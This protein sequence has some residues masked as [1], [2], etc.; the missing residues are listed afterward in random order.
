MTQENKRSPW[1]VQR[2]VIFALFLRELK[3]R[4]ESPTQYLWA[5]IEPMVFIL[6][7]LMIFV[8]IGR[9][10]AGNIPFPM[11]LL[12]GIVPW[13]FFAKSEGQASTAIPRNVGLFF[14]RQVKPIDTILTRVFLELVVFVLSFLIFLLIY[15]PLGWAS[16]P[17]EPLKL[18]AVYFVYVI[19]VFSVSLFLAVLIFFHGKMVSVPLSFFRRILYFISGVF[20]PITIFPQQYRSYFLWNPLI[21][22]MELSRDAYFA[23]YHSEYGSWS[24]L[25]L[26]TLVMFVI[27]MT[28]YRIN[29]FTLLNPST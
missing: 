16:L 19:L 12:T 24:F 27:G 9:K 5:I 29:R 6:F 1:F 8:V 2:S 10:S 21:H 3:T 28:Y 20:F 15:W 13:Q 17:N 23:E 4:F 25:L 26:S 11:F 14:Y 7:F 18:L 22:V